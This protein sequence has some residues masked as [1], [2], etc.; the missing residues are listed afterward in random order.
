LAGDIIDDLAWLSLVSKDTSIRGKLA[1]AS[2]SLGDDQIK[3]EKAERAKQ[4]PV[5]VAFRW[6]Q[7]NQWI[8]TKLTTWLP[9]VVR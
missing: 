2:P 9:L 7:L 3:R 4:S 8:T 5:I 6:L 1:I